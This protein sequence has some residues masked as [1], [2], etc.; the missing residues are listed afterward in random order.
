MVTGRTRQQYHFLHSRRRW[1]SKRHCNKTKVWSQFKHFRPWICLFSPLKASKM[2]Q[3]CQIDTSY[4][5]GS[6]KESKKLATF[7]K[8][9]MSHMRL[10][11][12]DE[13]INAYFVFRGY[14]DLGKSTKSQLGH[15]WDRFTGKLIHQKI[16]STYSVFKKN[17]VVT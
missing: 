17:Q 9:R 15:F 3:L 6:Q 13:K 11:C 12:P 2:E 16:M 5:S 1:L 4:T 7:M 10:I 14:D 8:N